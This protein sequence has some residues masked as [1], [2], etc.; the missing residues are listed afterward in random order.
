M[1][2]EE[3]IFEF[4]IC[5]SDGEAKMENINPS[6]LTHFH[7]LVYEYPNTFLF[8]FSVICRTYEYTTNE[9]KLKHFPST[10]KDSTLRWFMSLEGNNITTWDYMKNTLSE[11]YQDYCRARDTRYGIFRMTQGLDE[12]LEYFEDIFQ[13]S[14][15][16]DQNSFWMK[17]HS[18]LSYSQ[19]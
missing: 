4:L 3:E 10:L 18:I 13:L 16:R 7:G 1:A 14:Y 2:G 17:I 8:E 5:E 11:S 12:S 6:A 19:E 9:Q 15:K